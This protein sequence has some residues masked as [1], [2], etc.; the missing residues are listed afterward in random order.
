MTDNNKLQLEFMDTNALQDCIGTLKKGV[1]EG[2]LKGCYDIEYTENLIVS[3]N[4]LR[5]SVNNL[6]TFQNFVAQKIKDTNQEASKSTENIIKPSKS[7][8]PPKPVL[9]NIPEDSDILEE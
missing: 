2:L 6:N 7:A 4:N 1:N 8:L 3:L 5:R 9:S